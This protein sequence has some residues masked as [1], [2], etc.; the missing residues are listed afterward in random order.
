MSTELIVIK[1]EP[2]IGYDSIEAVSKEVDAVISSL[3]LE[4]QV[5]TSQTVKSLKQ[6]RADLNNQFKAFE[7]QRNF[8]KNAVSKPYLDFEEKYKELIA[9]KFK[10]ADAVLKDKV[11]TVENDL[12][13]EKENSL[14]DYYNE[15][16]QSKDVDFV[17]FE[18]VGLNV[19]LSASVKSL[20]EK[21]NTFVE[22]VA[23][24]LDLIKSLPENDEFKTD[25][26]V[27]YKRCL[28]VNHSLRIVQERK[29]AKEIELQKAEEDKAKVQELP[30]P[31]QEPKRQVLSAP[32]QEEPEQILELSFTV[33]G[34]LE[35]LKA[36]KQFILSNNIEIVK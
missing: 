18:N 4:N 16:C 17:T 23:K 6:T 7:E 33:K 19:T 34:S 13:T 2:I 29:K 30:K 11:L 3:D 26:L 32:K 12:K 27:D 8:V 28:D 36:L 22:T 1:Q 20:K 14:K 25:V 5:A 24:D 31:T 21:I 15:L 9:S 10:N 35:Q